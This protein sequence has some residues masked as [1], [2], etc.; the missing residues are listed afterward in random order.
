MA[1]LAAEGITIHPSPPVRAA[2]PREDSYVSTKELDTA[3][4]SV[5]NLP[6]LSYND[7]NRLEELHLQ[8]V[9]PTISRRTKILREVSCYLSLY[10]SGYKR[11]VFRHAQAY[12]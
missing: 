2:L 11:V 10:I 4:P 3:T 1:A 5:E 7:T 12:S 6:S 9:E 8:D